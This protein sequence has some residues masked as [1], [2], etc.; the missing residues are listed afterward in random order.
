MTCLSHG[1]RA[2]AGSPRR[3]CGARRSSAGPK[4]RCGWR[5]RRDGQPRRAGALPARR[6][7]TRRGVLGLPAGAR[8][9][10]ADRVR[11]A[12]GL[13][14][15]PDEPSPRRKKGRRQSPPP[16]L[17]GVRRPSAAFSPTG[18]TTGGGGGGGRRR[19]GRRRR[20]RRR[21]AAGRRRGGAA[22]ARTPPKLNNRL[23]RIECELKSVLERVVVRVGEVETAGVEVAVLQAEIDAPAE[24][25]AR[26]R[27]EL[28]GQSRRPNRR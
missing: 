15:A 27:E 17:F 9:P 10:L 25:V 7:A 23:A 16:L 26:G 13:V 20:W 19:R 14:G 24:R 12:G 21:Q 18:G 22:A 5:C 3:R 8:P 28:P 11:P 2:G 6:L 1:R 4:A